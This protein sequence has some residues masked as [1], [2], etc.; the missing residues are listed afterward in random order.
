MVRAALLLL[1]LEARNHGEYH[2]QWHQE[3]ALVANENGAYQ[4]EMPDK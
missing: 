3:H 4:S 2:W 1:M